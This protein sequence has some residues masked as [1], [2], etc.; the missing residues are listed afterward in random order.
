MFNKVPR[1]KLDA[2][3]DQRHCRRWD[4]KVVGQHFSPL[5][6]S[7]VHHHIRHDSKRRVN[8]ADPNSGVEAVF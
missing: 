1:K 8:R 2:P 5:L 3:V 4:Q 6:D 7:T